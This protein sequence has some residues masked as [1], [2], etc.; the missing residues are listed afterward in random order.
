MIL[1]G[2]LG[3]AVCAAA[4]G[5]GLASH[6][7]DKSIKPKRFMFVPVYGQVEHYPAARRPAQGSDFSKRAARDRS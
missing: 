1:T 2:L 6:S 7:A 4:C 5:H 3:K